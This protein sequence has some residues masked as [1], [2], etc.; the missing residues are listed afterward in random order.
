LH[1]VSLK[2]SVFTSQGATSARAQLGA[3]NRDGR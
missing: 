2:S 1:F 3:S